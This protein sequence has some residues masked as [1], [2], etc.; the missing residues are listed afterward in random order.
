MF[1]CA[2]TEGIA[3]V[4]MNAPPVNAMSDAW[5]QLNSVFS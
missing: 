1:A 4:T 3:T 2:V 5:P